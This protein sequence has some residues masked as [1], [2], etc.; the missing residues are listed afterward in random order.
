MIRVVLAATIAIAPQVAFSANCGQF[1]QRQVVRQ[2]HRVVQQQ[3]VAHVQQLGHANQHLQQYYLQQIAPVQYYSVGAAI[4]EQ[5]VAERIA[6]LVEQKLAKQFRQLQDLPGHSQPAPQPE[7]PGATVLAERCANCHKPGAKAVTDDAAPTMFDAA[8]NWTGTTDQASKAITLSK[9]GAM[10]P[11]PGKS[12]D[13][14]D[15]LSLRAFLE[16]RSK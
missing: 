2:Q 13:D 16:S 7:H 8:G 1:V 5:A 14:D 15:F 12:L 9:R 11:A 3:A 4:Q 10:P 6:K